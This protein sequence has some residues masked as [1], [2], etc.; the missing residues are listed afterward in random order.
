MTLTNISD[1]QTMKANLLLNFS[2][3]GALYIHLE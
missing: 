3:G 2:F 1:K